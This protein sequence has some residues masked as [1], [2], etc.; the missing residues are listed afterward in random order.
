MISLWFLLVNSESPD[1][2][3]ATRKVAVFRWLA[4]LSVVPV[5]CIALY[6]LRDELSPQRLAEHDATVRQFC[7]DYPLVT[8]LAAFFGYTIA[9]SLSVPAAALMAMALGWLFGLPIAI[10]IV[11]IGSTL[12][13]IS[14]FLASRWLL[15]DAVRIR[16]EEPLREIE[17][18]LERDGAFYLFLLRLIPVIPFCVI[19]IVMGL[20]PIRLR[21]FWWI[22]QLGMLPGSV[23]FVAAGASVPT[24]KV[25]FEQGVTGILTL[26]VLAVFSTLGLLPLVAR[27]MYVQRRAL[28]QSR[29][30][31]ESHARSTAL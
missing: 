15:R 16:F 4:L 11:S 7:S 9:T 2:V 28:K 30:S 26:K 6:L 21:S 24:L 17:T 25:L 20:T 12:G 1:V 10:V 18:V 8:V 22:S 23:L 27:W 14:A 19:N 5:G 29:R 13:A 31:I 3:A